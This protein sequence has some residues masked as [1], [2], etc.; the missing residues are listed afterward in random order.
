MHRESLVEGQEGCLRGVL[1][2]N[3]GETVPYLTAG[4][5]QSAE[6][7]GQLTRRTLS[8]QSTGPLSFVLSRRLQGPVS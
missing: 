8:I 4:V 3:L 2:A 5:L 6:E 7:G 1:P